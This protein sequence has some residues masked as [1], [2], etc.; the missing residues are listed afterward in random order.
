M[1]RI[2]GR[3]AFVPSLLG[4]ILTDRLGPDNRIGAM[5]SLI[6]VHKIKYP[7]LIDAELLTEIQEYL[8]SLSALK[9]DRNYIV[10]SVW[11]KASETQLSHF[12]ISATARS[13]IDIEGGPC[14]PLKAIE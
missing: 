1:E 10:H 4:Y 3:L 12:D 11:S 8:P 7:G 5:H 9:G 13:G 14:Q 2:L 6:E